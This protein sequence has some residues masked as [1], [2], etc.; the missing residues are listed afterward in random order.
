MDASIS[1]PWLVVPHL[2]TEK[3]MWFRSVRNVPSTQKARLRGRGSAQTWQSDRENGWKW[4]NMGYPMLPA[5]GENVHWRGIRRRLSAGT[6]WRELRTRRWTVSLV[7]GIL[8]GPN[9]GYIAKQKGWCCKDPF[10]VE[11]P[12]I[13]K[14]SRLLV[15]SLIPCGSW[16]GSKMRSLFGSIMFLVLFQKMGPLT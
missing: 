15:F 5:T 13:L 7:N 4:M 14:Y 3:E 2:I 11:V 9:L 8:L 1:F 10:C 12:A 16:F 6:F